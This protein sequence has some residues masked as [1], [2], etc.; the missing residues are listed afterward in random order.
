MSLLIARICIVRALI[1][2]KILIMV[3]VALVMALVMALV[4]A[5][6]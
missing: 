5:E 3:R 6:C 1:G 2:I 4:R